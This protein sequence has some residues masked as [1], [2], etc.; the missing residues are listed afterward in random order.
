MSAQ[1]RLKGHTI[2][3]LDQVNAIDQ[4]L[5]EARVLSLVLSGPETE[6]YLPEDIHLLAYM[7]HERIDETLK[8]LQEAGEAK[9]EGDKIR[10]GATG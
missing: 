3:D 7:A 9:P 4:N 6:D 5:N 2:L 8:I 1:E 10:R